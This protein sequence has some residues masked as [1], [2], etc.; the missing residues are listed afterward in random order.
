MI[1]NKKTI[2][3]IFAL[4]FIIMIP[5]SLFSGVWKSVEINGG[6]YVPGVV[7]SPI[8]PNLIYL[9]TDV[10]GFYRWNNAISRWIPL[11]DMYGPEDPSTTGGES[12]AADPVNS[13]IVYAAAGF[14]GNG[15]ILR[16]VNQGDTW[17]LYPVSIVMAGNNDGREA[18]ERLAIDPNLPSKLYFGSR[19]Q[20]L[21][22]STDSAANW[23]QVTS[24]PVNGDFDYGLSWVI[25][26]S[27][28]TFGSASQTIYVGV[29]AMSSSNCNVYR[30]TNGG[31]SWT[32]IPGGPNNM[33]T[34]RASLGADGNLWIAYASGGY[35][36]GGMLNGQIWK[37]NTATL[38]WTNVTPS[39]GPPSGAGGYGGISVDAQ[40][41]QHAVVCT[42]D[43]WSGNDKVL[44]TMN[45]G[46]SWTW[47]KSSSTGWNS[48]PFSIFDNNGS[49]WT[50]GCD[51]TDSGTMGWP[52]SVQ[53]DPFN[54]ARAI[55]GTGG[56]IWWSDNITAAVQPQGVTWTFRDNGIEETVP[57]YMNPSAAGGV[58]FSSMGDVGGMRHTNLDESPASGVY[59]SD[60]FSNTNMLDYAEL[61]TDIVVRVGHSGSVT[62]DI[63]YS[64]NNGQ[65]WTSWG[66]APPGYTNYNNMDS[67]AVSADGSR[68]LVS[69]T[70]T[71]GTPAY[72]TSLGGPWTLCNGLPSGACVVSDRVNPSTFYATS[73]MRWVYGGNVTV[74]RSTD[75]GANFTQVNSIPVNYTPNGNGSI[76]IPRPV[77]G[78]EGEFWL[79][80]D[81]ALY[82]ITNG[83]ST[84]TKI[85]NVF[86]LSQVGFGKAALG[87]T[88]PAVYLSGYVNG[89]FGIYRCDDGIGTAWTKINDALHQFGSPGWVQGDREIYGR[90]YIAPGARGIVYCDSAPVGTATATPSITPPLTPTATPTVT[91]TSTQ[92]PVQCNAIIYSG[93][94]PYNLSSGG[95]YAGTSSTVTEVTSQYYSSSHSMQVHFVWDDGWYQGMAFNWANWNSTRVFNASG[96]TFLSMWIK[97][98]IGTI[99]SLNISL[100]DSAGGGTNSLPVSSY[101]AGGITTTW[102]ELKIPISAFTG[103]D[104]SALW[105]L[106][107]TT[108]G[109][110]AGNQIIYVD[111]ISF[112]QPCVSPTNT[113]T[114]TNSN[115]STKTVTQTCTLTPSKTIT[116]SSTMTVSPSITL[117][118]QYTE[119]V[120]GTVTL[121][122]TSVLYTA[123]NT[124][125][126]TLTTTLTVTNTVS[127]TSTVTIIVTLTNTVTAGAT[128]TITP[129]I[130]KTA[131]A[132]ATITITPIATRTVTAS[133]TRT[134]T[135]IVVLSFTV[136]RTV[137]ATNTPSSSVT[138]TKTYTPISTATLTLTVTRTATNTMPTSTV[139]ITA[140]PLPLGTIGITDV[141]IYPNPIGP[142]DKSMNF[143]VKVTG[144]AVK[145][146]IKIYT[147]SSRKIMDNYDKWNQ[148]LSYP[149]CTLNLPLR[150]LPDMANGIY[151]CIITA[152]DSKGKRA[153][154]KP[155]IIV[156]IR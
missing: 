10:G 86:P 80:T 124:P 61:N 81:D 87:Q 96:A 9:R 44:Q 131:T 152:E 135:N 74:Y 97:T 69:P 7:F 85:T 156:I 5:S 45:G 55:F 21:W 115:T 127:L 28:G 119:S 92:T 76:V 32:L 141:L 107:I 103:A 149:E 105:E 40:N 151:Y 137:T 18:G 59:C 62:N 153:V 79:T 94:S 58:L 63:A 2:T 99:N 111:D 67:V 38:S 75:Y 36:P 50:R 29:M 117:T 95:Y 148:G 48:P 56:G 6:G 112:L 136:T 22:V 31:T 57:I 108:G 113:P 39:N 130:T 37:L 100:G 120:T 11:N 34:P 88:H 138:S 150:S 145:M 101:L 49:I 60:P 155:C 3:N 20:G 46:T 118:P 72:A 84:V 24:F 73:P 93:E 123:T 12:L 134:E 139:V 30:S 70:N 78:I 15:T 126:S 13:N 89:N 54:S 133:A 27:G 128:D 132:S 65:T 64:T 1:G 91:I 143:K 33:I 23:S 8:E 47:I 90:V 140:T 19:Q 154:S 25:F 26:G 146:G 43:W 144:S 110:Q 122:H 104:M 116:V 106:R 142:K 147:V 114:V 51:A 42:M 121:T 52:S 68:V 53:I 14:S 17:T 41:P 71:N 109:S 83:G 77:F 102:Q 98:E 35:G 129:S 82:R 4:L 16:S 125:T 66:S